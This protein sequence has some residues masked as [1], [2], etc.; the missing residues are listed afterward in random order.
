MSKLLGIDHVSLLVKNA[1]KSKH[2]Y[3]SVL[4]LGLL[5]RP[6]LGFPGYWLD[7]GQGQ[8]L[9]LLQVARDH[10]LLDKLPEHGG[11]DF[12][13]ALRVAE[14]AFFKRR[15]QDAGVFYN[16]SQSGRKALFFRDPDGNAVELTQPD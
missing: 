7:L 6:D 11:R 10:L 15:L 3:Q 8:T 2:F 12:H 13:L 1:D 4:G 5:P 14:I 16:E 9:H